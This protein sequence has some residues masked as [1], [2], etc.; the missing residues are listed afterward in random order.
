MQT[1]SIRKISQNKGAP[2]LWLEGK[3]TEKAGFKPGVRYD[4]LVDTENKR[5]SLQLIDV[6]HRTVSQKERGGKTIPVIDINSKQVLQVFE[7]MNC[8]RV[9]MRTNQIHIIPEVVEVRKTERLNRIDAK[10]RSG[11]PLTV[12]SISHG[13]GILSNALHKGLLKAGFLSNLKFANDIR[14]DLLEQAELVNDAWNS[15]TIRVSAPMQSL[16]LDSWMISKLG[17]V[18]ILEGGLPC[19]AASV[20]GRS[21]NG[22]SMA[23]QHEEVGH[24]V[25]PFIQLIGQLNPAVVLLENVKPYQSTASMWIL[26][27][28]LRDMGY[29]VHESI[30]DAGDFNELE[31][32]ER[33]CMVAVTA[34]IDF[35]FNELVKPEKVTR[36]L[37]D[38]MENVADDDKRWSSF[39]YLVKHQD[40]H[41]AKGN[42][43][44]MQLFDE[45]S[46]HINTITK[47]YAKIRSTDPKIKH[48]SNGLMRQLT[49]KEHARVKGIP[50][51]FID[52]M[53]LTTGHEMLGQSVCYSPFMAVGELLGN[54][55]RKQR[56]Q[57]NTHQIDLMA[58]A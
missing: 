38:I 50:E 36:K 2:R 16:V 52:G 13:G 12:G 21:K 15:N 19:S 25:A 45:N 5:V 55:L 1:Y 40:K 29:Q 37:G 44:S 32:R 20:A 9:I 46:G 43:F 58:A 22:T 26:R 48:P 39:D 27:H 11:E 57:V 17:Y 33:L 42:G 28:S 31:H 54:S 10:I 14:D 23:E 7:G 41:A 4:I 3:S 18:D 24:L 49:L 56:L 30:L 47:G 6:G 8:V 35:D 34:G 51:H 53:N